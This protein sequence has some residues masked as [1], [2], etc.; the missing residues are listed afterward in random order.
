VFRRSPSQRYFSHPP[1]DPSQRPPWWEW[2]LTA[3]SSPPADSP[4]VRTLSK[5][6]KN[7][8]KNCYERFGRL[9][10]LL[11][12]LVV[13]QLAPSPCW[14][15]IELQIL[16]K[17]GWNGSVITPW[18]WESSPL[19]ILHFGSNTGNE[20]LCKKV[21]PVRHRCCRFPLLHLFD[22][23]SKLRSL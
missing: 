23:C 22:N 2:G 1:P 12:H 11:L 13:L 16:V 6:V 9:N 5:M 14:L 17:G 3:L 18:T 7:R 19:V 15:L 10:L 8:S 21:P 20:S 4:T